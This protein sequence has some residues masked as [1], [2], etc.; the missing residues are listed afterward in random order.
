MEKVLDKIEGNSFVQRNPEKQ[1]MYNDVNDTFKAFDRDG[2]ATLQFPEY[3]EAWRF[4]NLPGD[5]TAVKASFDKVDIDRS[6]T[7]DLPEFLYSIMGEDAS[8][9]GYL[10]DMELLATLLEQLIS[11]GGQAAVE[12]LNMAQKRMRSQE[13]GKDFNEVVQRMMFK[14]GVTRIGPFTGDE[15]N[16]QLDAAF[17]SVR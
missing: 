14:C 12:A 6:G 2:N 15:L 5:S 4:L 8:K 16:N 3:S 17:A 13:G 1:Q 9:Y 7:V 10:S 11:T